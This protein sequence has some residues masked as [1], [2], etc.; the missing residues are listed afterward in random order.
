MKFTLLHIV[1]IFLLIVLVY[2]LRGKMNVGS[3][4]SITEY[5]GLPDFNQSGIAQG[6]ESNSM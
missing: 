4:G 5:F 6:S 2:G 1:L 3:V